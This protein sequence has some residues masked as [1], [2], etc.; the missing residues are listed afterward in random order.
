MP[1]ARP[2]Y[3]WVV[4]AALA[5]TE[6]TSWGVIYYG[7]GVFLK[8]LEADFGW[9]RLQLTGAFSVALA[10]Q[11]VAAVAVGRWLDRA[12]P[13]LLMTCGSIAATL[14]TLAWSRT[15]SLVGF[16]LLWAFLGAVMSTVLYDPAFTVVAKWFVGVERRRALT[17]V[18]LV[19]GFASTIFLPLEDALISRYGWR[20][21][22]VILAVIL[23]SVTIPLH[24]LV[25]RPSPR[26]EEPP[27]VLL[28]VGHGIELRELYR[29]R[30]FVGLAFALVCFAFAMS[31]L[32]VH[33]V[34]YLI[35][36]GYSPEFAAGVT[37]VLGA[38]QVAGRLIFDPLH[39]WLSRRAVTTLV[40]G[41]MAAALVLLPSGGGTAVVW[42]FVLVYGAARGMATL[43]RATL[44]ADLFGAAR[45]GTISGVLT[46]LTTTALA[47]A[48]VLAG[49]LYDT[50][51]GY[52]PVLWLIAGVALAGA[53]AANRIEA[54]SR[55]AR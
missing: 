13:R 39:R 9:S 28:P 29:T 17:A 4:V 23:G 54:P 52:Q 43:L 50:F 46:F 10:C 48:P 26:L 2:N 19:A 44:V 42:T 32:S 11:G 34:A 51:G 40:F 31:A 7:F 37:G 41:V 6:T 49:A 22:L 14:G 8:P 25:L 12:S 30:A 20:Q 18:T 35:E 5:V 47:S 1:R 16:Y 27:D 3:G 21:A 15:S 38:M 53:V 24:A 55:A 33:Q 36:R 45:Y